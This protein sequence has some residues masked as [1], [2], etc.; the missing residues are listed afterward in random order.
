MENAS[1]WKERLS[2]RRWHN[3]L[4]MQKKVAPKLKK[5]ICVS[6]PSMQDTIQE[7][8]VKPEKLEVI[9]NGIDVDTFKPD[10]NMKI[11]ENRIVTTAS[12]DIPLKGLR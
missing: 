6:K 8:Q 1:N 2:S 7:L 4:P 3:F 11:I 5:I 10:K 12:A 9:L